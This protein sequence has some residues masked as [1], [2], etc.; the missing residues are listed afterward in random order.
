MAFAR[1]GVTSSFEND[2]MYRAFYG[3]RRLGGPAGSKG[4]VC[5]DLK[6]VFF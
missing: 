3:T 1:S 2:H 5:K 6:N 4:N